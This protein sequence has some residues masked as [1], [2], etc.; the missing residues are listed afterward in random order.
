MAKI[1]PDID[2]LS[3]AGNVNGKLDVLQ[4]NGSY[5]PN[6]TIII[7][8]FK[9]NDFL[10]GSFD[11]TITGNE[12]LTNYS[13]DATI[14]ND[15]TRSFGAKGNIF[16]SGRYSTIDVTLDFNAFNLFPL[17]P[18]LDGVLSDIRG[19]ANGDVNV[20]GD[21]RKPDING[22][23]I[24]KNGGLGIPYLNV[25]YDFNTNALTVGRN[26]SNI[27]NS[28]ADLVVNTQGAAF[29]LV[30]SG[31]ATTGWTYTEK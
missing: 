5:L 25:D 13:V 11:A 2:S 21:L 10:L 22:D 8:D 18:L 16:V 9:V 27:A 1:T 6:S 23:L 7:D 28:A 20:V 4:K 15:I 29:G 19:E 26:G 30:Y 3:L 24:L 12:S 14:K 31:D 17:N